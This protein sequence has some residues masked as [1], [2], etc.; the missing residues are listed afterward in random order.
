MRYARRIAAAV[1]AVLAVPAIAWA[2]TIGGV[3]YAPQ[4]D[5]TDFWTVADNKPF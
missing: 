4:Y 1:A 2:A 3:Y 5:Y